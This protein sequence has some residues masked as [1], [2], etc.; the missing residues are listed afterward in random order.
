[1]LELNQLPCPVT[2]RCHG[3][4]AHRRSHPSEHTLGAAHTGLTRSASLRSC[5]SLS[6]SIWRDAA[7]ASALM[8]CSCTH[9]VKC[10]S[11]WTGE[12]GS[13]RHRKL[14]AV[15]ARVQPAPGATHRGLTVKKCLHMCS[16]CEMHAIWSAQNGQQTALLM[17]VKHAPEGCAH[18][19]G[20][21]FSLLYGLHF[22][23]LL[24][25]CWGVIVHTSF[26]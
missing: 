14:L 12:S 20:C 13:S 17:L 9:E 3:N 4:P 10:T 1:M 21:G 22:A 24:G 16:S 19:A 2:A 5:R 26:L 11:R 18:G 23:S 8:S 15:Q 25:L 7:T 6:S